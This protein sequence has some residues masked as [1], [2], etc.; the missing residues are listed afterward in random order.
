MGE[1]EN[2]QGTTRGRKGCEQ[3]ENGGLLLLGQPSRSIVSLWGG[4]RA[5]SL[6]SGCYLERRG[7]WAAWE[8]EGGD[9][10]WRGERRERRCDSR[11]VELGGS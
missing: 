11:E 7:M 2:S 5:Q 10:G 6:S 3:A 4:I 1:K 9:P 8:A